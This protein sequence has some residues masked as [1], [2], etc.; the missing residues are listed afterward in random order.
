MVEYWRLKLAILALER[1]ISR[2]AREEFNGSEP[3]PLP[4][5]EIAVPVYEMEVPACEIAVPACEMVVPI[6]WT[7]L[8]STSWR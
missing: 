7:G 6:S 1:A 5:C 2:A 4:V 8:S 3:L